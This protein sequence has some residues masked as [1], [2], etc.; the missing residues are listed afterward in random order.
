M[1]AP[2]AIRNNN[3][4]NLRISDN[5][6]LGKVYPNTD[7]AFEQFTSPIYGIRAAMVNIKTHCRRHPGLTLSGLINIWAPASDG[8]RP[9]EY[10]ARVKMSA[11]IMA[12]E[13][14]LPRDRGQMTRLTRAMAEVESGTSYDISLFEGAFDMLYPR[15]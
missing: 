3:P 7:G 11:G 12:T 8:N 15:T 13:K 1:P 4:L 5:P 14:I 9:R 2:R 6:W 10:I